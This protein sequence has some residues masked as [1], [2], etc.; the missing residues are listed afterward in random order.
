LYRRQC[1]GAA[2]FWQLSV[3]RSRPRPGG[4]GFFVFLAA[5]ALK[6]LSVRAPK[7]AASRRLRPLKSGTDRKFYSSSGAENIISYGYTKLAIRLY[8]VAPYTGCP[9]LP[10][11][12][13]AAAAGRL[14]YHFK[15]APAAR[16]AY[17]GSWA[18]TAS[19]GLTVVKYFTFKMRLPPGNNFHAQ[20]QIGLFLNFL[21][22]FILNR[23]FVF[24]DTKKAKGFLASETDSFDYFDIAAD[25]GDF[26]RFRRFFFHVSLRCRRQYSHLSY[27]KLH[28]WCIMKHILQQKQ[29]PKP[30]KK[31]GSNSTVIV[32]ADLKKILI[33]TPLDY[34]LDQFC[35]LNL[36]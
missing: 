26:R 18:S 28:A 4:S 9:T 19:L 1:W 32:F 22:P 11:T 25:F 29:I 2:L 7:K 20:S 14:T 10:C 30:K 3:L 16:I 36:E 23:S 33:W 6:F 24:R 12:S 17:Q 15:S 31:I 34:F 8:Q 21:I 35:F 5:P 27:L 13:G